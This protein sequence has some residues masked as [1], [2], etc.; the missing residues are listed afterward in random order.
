M[1]EL[2]LSVFSD[3]DIRA[4]IT[5]LE[6]SNW[7]KAQALKLENYDPYPKQEQFHGLGTKYRQRLLSAGNQLGKMS[8]VDEKILT[9]DRWWIRI[10]DVEPGDRVIAGDGTPTRVLAVYPQGI[11]PLV[12]VS[13]DTGASHVCGDEHLWRVRAPRLS[14]EEAHWQVRKTHELRAAFGDTPEPG[15]RFFIPANGGAQLDEVS[16]PVDP[17]LLG[18]LLSR[19]TVT[20]SVQIDLSRTHTPW[21]DWF[22]KHYGLTRKTRIS[23]WE[24]S[25]PA[26][27]R[28][29]L[30]GLGLAGRCSDWRIPEIY[31]RASL[32]QRVQFLLG[33]IESCSYG[34]FRWAEGAGAHISHLAS[35]A[36]ALDVRDLIF[37]IGG[38]AAVKAEG[39]R[40][41][42]RLLFLAMPLGFYTQGK[43]GLQWFRRG[44][45]APLW[46]D[47]I[48][49]SFREVDPGPAVCIAVEHPS[50]TY[51]VGG[52][53]VTHNTYAGAAETAYHLTGRYPPWWTGKRF[54]RPVS[55][56]AG[57]ES[58]E[59][60]RDGMQRLLL[61][62]PA[63]EEEWG[64]G[65]I[66]R[67]AIV[68]KPKRR[69]G[70]KDAID[71]VVVRHVQ[72]GASVIR[73]KSYDQGRSKWQ[74]D[75]VDAVWLDEEPPYD[76]Y[77]E[78]VTR[79]NAVQGPVFITFTPLKGMSKVVNEFFTMPGANR[80]VIKMTIN[81]VRHYSKEQREAIAASYTDTSTR[82]ARLNGEPVLGSGLVFPVAAELIICPPIMVPDHWAK[83]G[84]LDFGYD[85]PF[86][87]VECAWD[88]DADVFYVLREYRE[89]LKGPP[90]HCQVLR[91]WGNDL[92]WQWPRDGLQHD[93]GSCSQLA[94]QYRRNGLKMHPDSVSFS[95]GS[96]GVESGILEM[97]ARMTEGRWKV[98][99]TCIKWLEEYRL[100]HRK[101]GEIV[102]RN[103]DLICASRY[104]LMGKRFARAGNRR[105]SWETRQD[106]RPRTALG[107]G[108]VTLD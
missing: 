3:T 35:F 90:E 41:K 64:T 28:R 80:V 10:G 8:H 21:A 79:T 88:R 1:G 14:G 11:K 100:Y 91:Q 94:A 104:A 99:E 89:R 30:S 36:L 92:G 53:L 17:Y 96:Y 22:I 81:D 66:P 43:H 107:A 50:R 68:Q 84:G 98:F 49:V 83:V 87:A 95:D 73:F 48:M 32:E 4:A 39:R 47:P 44:E 26:D 63:I 97:L 103:D 19:G 75:T 71:A 2:D 82:D 31:M 67:D 102:K 78:A 86:G 6:E 33:L 23:A 77:E 24:P 101:E 38:A 74:A 57:S 60:T 76:V 7:K 69:P 25:Y 106:A 15:F 61:G 55:I 52:H 54:S 29:R 34:Y 42:P 70:V 20:K 12:R 108:Q 85:H 18:V 58:G 45:G 62:P 40:V 27:I 56:L 51:I 59:L 65:L 16:L 72:G 13:F 9:P 5:R 93:K 37:S 105:G 46:Y